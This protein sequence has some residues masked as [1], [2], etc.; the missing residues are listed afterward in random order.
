MEIV[1]CAIFILHE[2]PP[3]YNYVSYNKSLEYPLVPV[4]HNGLILVNT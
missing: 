1:N 4:I 2:G 3:S